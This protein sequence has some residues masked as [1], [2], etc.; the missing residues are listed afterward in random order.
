MCVLC[1]VLLRQ[2]LCSNVFILYRAYCYRS[3]FKT[4]PLG[5]HFIISSSSGGDSP[6]GRK[7]KANLNVSH[8]LDPDWL[9]QTSKKNCKSN[10][11]PSS[12]ILPS[13][14]QIISNMPSL[15]S[16]NRHSVIIISYRLP[17]KFLWIR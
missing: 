2:W 8:Y 7:M 12:P 9:I 13:L 3:Y 10:Y 14:Q 5:Y 1:A 17:K 16:L 6:S 11:K 4:L 15:I